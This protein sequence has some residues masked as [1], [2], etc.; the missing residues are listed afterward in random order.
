NDG[1]DDLFITSFGGNDLF[2]NEGGSNRTNRTNGA[3]RGTPI[4]PIS[5][6]SPISPLFRDV[7]SEMGLDRVHGTGYATSAAFG[8]Y[9]N[10][11]RLDLYVCYYADWTWGRDKTCRDASDRREYCT[12]E[13]Y[14]P[15]TDRLYHNDGARFTDVS[16]KAGIT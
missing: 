10:D 14:E 16:E 13:I 4:A 1:Y 12:P 5:P 9:D 11:G 7:T 15:E 3:D 6:I 8:D 2:R